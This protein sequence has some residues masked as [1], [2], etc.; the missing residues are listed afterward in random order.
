MPMLTMAVIGLPV[1]PSHSRDR[2]WFANAA[3][4]SSVSCTSLTTSTPSTNSERSRGIRRATWS[5]ARSSVTLMCSPANIASRRASTPASRA[6]S[7][8]R[9]R[10]SSSTRCLE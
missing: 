8:R 2:T 10:I 1:W 5:T 4:R 6:S 9:E 7:N 3:I